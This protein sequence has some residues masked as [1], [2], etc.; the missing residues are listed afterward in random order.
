M[1]W[2]AQQ[3]DGSSPPPSRPSATQRRLSDLVTSVTG[4]HRALVREVADSLVSQ[5]FGGNHLDDMIYEIADQVCGTLSLQTAC[6]N[7]YRAANEVN[8]MRMVDQLAVLV[9]WMGGV[10]V[11]KERLSKDLMISFSPANG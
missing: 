1:R 7:E 4:D 3:K 6:E 8:T 11:L 2:L 9:L 5:G 10:E